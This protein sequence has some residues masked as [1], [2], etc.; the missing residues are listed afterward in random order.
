[1][2]W[3]NEVASNAGAYIAENLAR[4]AKGK[5]PIEPDGFA[6][7]AIMTRS[8][9]GPFAC[10]RSARMNFAVQENGAAR[11]LLPRRSVEQDPTRQIPIGLSTSVATRARTPP[12][13][14]GWGESRRTSALDSISTVS[15]R[16]ARE[17]AKTSDQK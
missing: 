6:I 5:P 3:K 1:M 7:L 10:E 9:S 4:M 11:F 14:D 13:P 12:P 15:W 8:D 16:R 17:D 2:F